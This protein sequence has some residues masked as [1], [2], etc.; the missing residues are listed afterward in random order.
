MLEQENTTSEPSGEDWASFGGVDT[1]RAGSS[2][3][4]V[5]V[6]RG[7]VSFDRITE[8]HFD[9][10]MRLKLRLISEPHDKPEDRKNA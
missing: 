4:D 6:K 1:H 2:L 9:E 8:V 3:T 7:K 5:N 10:F